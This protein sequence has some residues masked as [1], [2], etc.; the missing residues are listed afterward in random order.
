MPRW[1][2]ADVQKLQQLVGEGADWMVIAAELDRSVEAV[3]M[4]AKRLGLNVVVETTPPSPATTTNE[5]EIPEDLFTVQESLQILAGALKRASEKGLD[6]LEIQR[7]NV[8][9]TLARSYESMF[10]RYMKY[11]I[12]EKQ[13]VEI[14]AKYARLAKE[15][16]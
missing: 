4:K 9:A 16:T 10:A 1:K 5:L 14:K 7:L 12:I 11:R 2:K 15:R 8:V 6:N 13:L 3:Q